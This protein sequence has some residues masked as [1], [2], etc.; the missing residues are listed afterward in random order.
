[1]NVVLYTEDFEPITVIDLPVVYLE[2]LERGNYV[3]LAIMEPAAL[4]PTDSI[5]A[6]RMEAL[7]YKTISIRAERMLWIDRSTKFVLI[8]PN[9]ELALL[10][11]PSWLPGQQRLA[12]DHRRTEQF[13]VQLMRAISQMGRDH[14]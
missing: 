2:M 1:M 13:V 7:S 8:T 4:A 6:M 14:G 12:N 11:R 9:D 5:D 10:L 3:R